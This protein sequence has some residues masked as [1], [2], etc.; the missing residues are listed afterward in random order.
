[1]IKA[2]RKEDWGG[3]K[4]LLLRHLPSRGIAMRTE[5]LLAREWLDITCWWEGESKEERE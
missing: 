3:R 1:V 2:G 5:A 4:R